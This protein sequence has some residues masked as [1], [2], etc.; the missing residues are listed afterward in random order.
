MC[1]VQILDRRETVVVSQE[2]NPGP[3]AKRRTPMANRLNHAAKATLRE[4]GITQ[5]GWLRAHP[6]CDVCG[7]PDDRCIGYHHGSS[8]DDGC[9]LR[10]WIEDDQKRCRAI[11]DAEPHRG[12]DSDELADRLG[13]TP[14]YARTLG[15]SLRRLFVCTTFIGGVGT[16]RVHFQAA[17]CP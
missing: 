1:T 13:I 7:C 16:P 3:S 9:D 5:A 4:Y 2:W 11:L 8:D 10:W 17:A 6:S 15:M 12:F 14:D